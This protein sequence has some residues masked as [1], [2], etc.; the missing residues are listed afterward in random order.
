MTCQEIRYFPA[1]NS[2]HYYCNSVI[3]NVYLKIKIIKFRFQRI[4]V[5]DLKLCNYKLPNGLC[6]TSGSYLY[7]LVVQNKSSLFSVVF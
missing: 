3:N 5:F 6:F 1:N 7:T 4:A 2:V